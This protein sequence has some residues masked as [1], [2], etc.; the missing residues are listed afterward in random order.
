[1]DILQGDVFEIDL[2]TGLGSEQSGKRPCI[3]ISNDVGNKFSQTVVITIMTSKKKSNLIT[4]VVLNRKKYPQFRH[5]NTIC[6]EQI[7]TVDKQRLMNGR[8]I[9]RIDFKAIQ[10]S[11]RCVFELDLKPKNSISEL[12]QLEKDI[13]ELQTCIEI[14]E[15]RNLKSIELDELRE[16]YNSKRKEYSRI[17]TNV[18]RET[19]PIWRDWLN[20]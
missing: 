15:K 6:L 7:R 4:H 16:E 9:G 3:V 12:R 14:L 1:M 11:L 10:K 17:S 18:L 2:G 19:E 20:Q 8:Y 13:E 5:D